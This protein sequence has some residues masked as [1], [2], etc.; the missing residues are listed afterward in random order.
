MAYSPNIQRTIE[1][2]LATAASATLLYFGNGLD[3]SWPLMWLAFLPLLLIA[4]R[5]PW[6]VAGL[7]SIT[8]IT[9]GNLNIWSYC[10]KTLGL[11]VAIWVGIVLPVALIFAVGVLL[12]RALVS[13][14]AVW[15]GLVALPAVG[16]AW[17]YV[18]NLTWPHGTAA[19]LAYSQLHFLPFLQLASITGPWGISFVLLLV[20]ASIAIAL[21]LRKISPRHALR[22]VTAG[23][24][25]LVVALVF[26]AI[27]L[28]FPQSQIS[29]V[30]VGLIASDL[31]TAETSSP[32]ADTERRFSD[33]AR[34]A[35]KLATD[36]AQVI[37]L[38]EGIGNI[39]E[40]REVATDTI[41]QSL[42]NQTGATIVTGVNNIDTSFKYD[43]ARVFT[44]HFAVQRY[45][46]EHLLPPFES[47]M[48]PG[49]T[50]LILRNHPQP[51]GVA[52]CKD[53]DFADPAR[54]YGKAG[55]GLMLV[56]AG[57][58]VVDRI[59]HG[60]IAIMRGVEDGFSVV[61]VA[62]RGFLTVSDG[63]GRI[64]AEMSSSAAPFATLLVN[65]PD[66]H[67]WTVYQ[68]LGD[69]FAWVAIALLLFV[70]VK[71]LRLRGH[72]QD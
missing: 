14:G 10:A 50:R 33:Y 52:I 4:L 13:R 25:T 29:S 68:V 15:S 12:F 31:P 44:P 27:R 37:V 16:V 43:E 18:R 54:A 24:G 42:A 2:F 72:T 21:H 53:M 47:D 20:P 60:H 45:E 22:V 40:G 30:K 23:V 36:G 35:H 65:V 34:A 63:H 64:L 3:P 70:I 1:A 62:R 7:T 28:T 46:K 55:V 69:W 6:W 56:P 41:F 19:S 71:M 67:H 26:G 61:R 51:W 49:T 58:F 66:A 57:D 8:A 5:N 11:P 38:P 17:E 32:E 39:I 9:L 48:Q 59:W